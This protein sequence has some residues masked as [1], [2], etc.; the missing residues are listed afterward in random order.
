VEVVKEDLD[1]KKKVLAAAAPHIGPEAILSSNTSGLSLAQM[2]SVLPDALK[3]R[4]LGTHFFNPPRY[5]KLLEVIP[6]RGW[7]RGS[8]LQR[9][10]PT[11]SPT[12]LASTR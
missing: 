6:T 7:G 9:T 2:A 12:A 11:S 10:H 8:F 3:P 4:F 5:M 1:I